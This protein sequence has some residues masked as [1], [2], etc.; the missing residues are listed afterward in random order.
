MNIDIKYLE[1]T[2]EEIFSIFSEYLK[3]VDFLKKNFEEAK[4][5]I[6]PERINYCLTKF[7]QAEFDYETPKDRGLGRMTDYTPRLG[8]YFRKPFSKLSSDK[9]KELDN[10]ITDLIVK[11]YLYQ[12]IVPEPV[13]KK[14]KVEGG[15]QLYQR[16]IPEIY[17]FDLG[18][19]SDTFRGL[20]EAV[21]NSNIENIK[22]FFKVNDIV[23][24]FFGKNKVDDIL[25]GYMNAGLVLRLAEAHDKQ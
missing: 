9:I 5:S 8:A 2:A 17:V 23:P 15:E 22:N 14:S 12:V 11:C 16:W 19:L 7:L 4:S 13:I 21:I 25:F 1:K 24:G 6:S 18:R 10:L 3:S 20:L